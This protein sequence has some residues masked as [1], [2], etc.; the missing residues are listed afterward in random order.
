MIRRLKC[1]A[2]IYGFLKHFLISLFTLTSDIVSALN[3]QRIVK[4]LL[5]RF[6]L[7]RRYSI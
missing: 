3:Y 5:Y 7:Y 1:F 2:H 4:R 6:V